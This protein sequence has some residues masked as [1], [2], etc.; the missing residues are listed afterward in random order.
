[1]GNSTTTAKEELHWSPIEKVV[2]SRSNRKDREFNERVF[3]STD[4]F[5]LILSSLGIRDFFSACCT[6]KTWW[7]LCDAELNWQQMAQNI[8]GPRY[9]DFFKTAQAKSWKVLCCHQ[10]NLDYVPPPYLQKLHT[11]GG[12]Y[13]KK[14]KEKTSKLTIR[15]NDSNTKD[16]PLIRIA[17]KG[18]VF[19][20]FVH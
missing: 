3:L 10:L 2:L 4:I 11:Q 9:I 7:R 5:P 15:N 12:L 20:Y 17:V 8:F 14:Q 6:C 19:F 13:P 1:M 18:D 16:G